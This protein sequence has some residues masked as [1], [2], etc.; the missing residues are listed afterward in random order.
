MSKLSVATRLADEAGVSFSKAQKYI[1]DVGLDN[2]TRALD[3][4]ATGASKTVNKWFKRTAVTGGIATGG[5]LA[6]RQ[7]DINKAQEIAQQEQ[8]QTDALAE[9]MD[10]DLPPEAK[11]ELTQQLLDQRD[12][13]ESDG[14]GFDLDD[15]IPDMGG[16]QVTLGLVVILVLMF[17]FGGD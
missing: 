15:M 2:A 8:S 6:W 1:D 7:Q 9:I 4:A 12:S 10:S 13:N 3:E 17:Q 16:M 11:R 5:A 14:E